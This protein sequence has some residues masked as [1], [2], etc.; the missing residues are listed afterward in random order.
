M[1]QMISVVQLVL[2]IFAVVFLGVL[3]RKKSMFS[4]GE[5]QA[6]QRFVIEFCLPC[7]LFQS[8]LTA[9]LGA[10]AL[11]GLLVPVV[12][13][14][15]TVWG[16]RVGK[17]WFPYFNTPFAFCCKETGMMGIPLFMI[18]FG[19]EQAYRMGILNLTQAIV[20]FP[21][22]AIMSSSSA[23]AAS[24]KKILGE[25]IRSPLILMSIG[26][27]ALNLTGVWTWMQ[28]IGVDQIVTDTFDYLSQ[29]VSMIMLFCVGYNFTMTPENTREIL[30][31][32]AVHVVVFLIVG[33][34]LQGALCLFPG[35]DA[36]TRWTMVIYAILPASFLL[37]SFG[38]CQLDSN[39]TS[40]VCSVTTAVTLAAFCMV[41][42]IVS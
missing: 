20:G 25:M 18:L 2:P 42:V 35:V 36:M 26:G 37:P 1:N 13:L 21:M 19:A 12:L 17:K 14:A 27:M 29:P 5:I 22:M 24:P 38:K 33:L 10:E 30:K 8:C 4:P 11:T 41:A 23:S 16:F 3:A 9:Q 39:I 31:M 40:G 34:V 15:T 28:G 7:L 6:F 32:S